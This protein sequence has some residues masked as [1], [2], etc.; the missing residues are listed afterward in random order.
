MAIKKLALL[1]V[2]LVFPIKYIYA[3]QAPATEDGWSVYSGVS[4]VLAEAG[5]QMPAQFENLDL[6]EADAQAHFQVAV[7]VPNTAQVE[8][9]LDQAE[10]E[11]AD[12]LVGTLE[13]VAEETPIPGIGTAAD[14]SQSIP[15]TR[16]A[17]GRLEE[18]E[19][20]PSRSKASSTS[21]SSSKSGES[22]VSNASNRLSKELR[23]QRKDFQS[24][25]LA[26]KVEKR[27]IEDKKT[28]EINEMRNQLNE[29]ETKRIELK[30][31]LNRVGLLLDKSYAERE[32][33]RQIYERDM[34]LA[35]MKERETLTKE[36]NHLEI[37]M[38]NK[39]A[40]IKDIENEQLIIGEQQ[41]ILIQEIDELRVVSE[42]KDS[43]IEQLEG[44]ISQLKSDIDQKNVR[45][46]ELENKPAQI[47]YRTRYRDN[48]NS[49]SSSSTTASS[50]S[51]SYSGGSSSTQ[52]FSE[53]S[54]RTQNTETGASKVESNLSNSYSN[55]NR[56]VN[57]NTGITGFV[58]NIA[59]GLWDGAKQLTGGVTGAAKS[60]AGGVTGAIN[61]VGS[62]ILRAFGW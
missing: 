5:M 50:G 42:S 38:L 39:I 17:L 55:T 23:S 31:E 20:R 10:E 11:P 7:D 34:E 59:N 9:Q 62:G 32:S 3:S 44:E 43:R 46:K 58:S 25:I 60:L 8:V 21:G 22:S 1:G 52:S 6:A 27:E 40:A 13:E 45:I 12:S 4:D 36:I 48:P 54:S 19:L 61:S 30:D 35:I 41:S 53:L 33:Q 14:S 51:N 26:L 28:Q 18:A 57:N 37:E 47:E 16:E 15:L 56:T 24:Q 2:F 49:G 29:S